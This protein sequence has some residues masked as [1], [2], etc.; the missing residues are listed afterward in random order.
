MAVPMFEGSVRV[1]PSLDSEPHLRGRN[2]LFGLP[3]TTATQR[4]PHPLRAR[5]EEDKRKG[6]SRD[7][8]LG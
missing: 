4:A 1:L 2:H 5:L 3:S 8:R 7:E 6:L